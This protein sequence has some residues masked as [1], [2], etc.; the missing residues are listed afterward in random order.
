MVEYMRGR[1]RDKTIYRVPDHFAL[2]YKGQHHLVSV[3]RSLGPL[4]Q[5]RYDG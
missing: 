3:L 1:G 5:Y 2:N 4:D